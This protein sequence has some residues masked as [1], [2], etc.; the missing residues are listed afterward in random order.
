[1]IKS[2]VKSFPKSIL[3][4]L[5]GLALI[6][7]TALA[8]EHI[9]N[10]TFDSDVNG[11]SNYGTGGTIAY[12]AT[13]GHDAVGSAMVTNSSGGNTSVGAMQCVDIPTAAGTEYYTA[14][15]WVYV[16]AGQ[17]AN[18]SY[19]YIRLRY[20][21]TD[22]C[23]GT[24]LGS[25]LDSNQIS[26][27]DTW[28]EVERIAQTVATAE[29]VQVRLYVRTSGAGGSPSVYFDDISL[30]DSTSTAITLTSLQARGSGSALPLAAAVVALGGVAAG[31][32]VWRRRK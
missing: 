10:G 25:N 27:T 1:M 17:P 13:M 6:F 21:P 11:W 22:D 4:V 16:P 5:V 15:G 23:T 29:S 24:A 19:A 9:T 20:Y 7:T 12:S 3:I 8:A 2:T 31:W 32:L 26:T 14:E 30:Y 28:Q 18:F